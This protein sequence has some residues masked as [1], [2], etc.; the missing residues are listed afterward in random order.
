M[1]ER[2]SGNLIISLIGPQCGIRISRSV[3]SALGW[4]KCV[5]FL[6]SENK[7]TM[8]IGPCAPEEPLALTVPAEMR[9]NKDRRMRIYCKQF[10]D[11]L[12]QANDMDPTQ[13]YA[14]TGEY[15]ERLNAVVFPLKVL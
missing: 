9:T 14:I 5:C 2:I 6:K 12:F 11:E 15:D 3:I 10:T 4:P 8:A 1:G 7:Q 13:N